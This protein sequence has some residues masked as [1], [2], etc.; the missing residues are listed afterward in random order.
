[1]FSSLASAGSF[2]RLEFSLSLDAAG[3]AAIQD[4]RPRQ[5]RRGPRCR[6]R[7]RRGRCYRRSVASRRSA[8]HRGKSG[9]PHEFIMQPLRVGPAAAQRSRACLQPPIRQRVR[10]I[11]M[12]TSIDPGFLCSRGQ[13][14][15][16]VK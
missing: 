3:G 7:L 6:C 14:I 5:C 10:H 1:M 16:A 2:A 13:N 4:P 11:H 9:R 15:V 12:V 8:K